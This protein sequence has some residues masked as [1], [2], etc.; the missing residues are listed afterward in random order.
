MQLY[1]TSLNGV[2]T[3]VSK[4]SIIQF[5]SLTD[6]YTVDV[7][8]YCVLAEQLELRIKQAYKQKIVTSYLLSFNKV[9]EKCLNRKMTETLKS[10][11]SMYASL[12]AEITANIGKIGILCKEENVENNFGNFFFCCCFWF[13]I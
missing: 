2:N 9:T 12:S 1:K 11:H 7:L 3:H 10:Y 6:L 13:G 5:L 8:C 4:I